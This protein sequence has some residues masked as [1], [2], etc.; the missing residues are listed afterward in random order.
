MNGMLF[1]YYLV[2]ILCIGAGLAGIADFIQY[3][4][5]KKRGE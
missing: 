3:W 4:V 5:D 1:A 2:W